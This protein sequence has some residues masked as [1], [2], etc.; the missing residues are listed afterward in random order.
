MAFIKYLLLGNV[1]ILLYIVASTSFNLPI[2]NQKD[3]DRNKSERMTNQNFR[4]N[5]S[6]FLEIF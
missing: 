2:K 6:I 3:K 4:F 5:F 1:V